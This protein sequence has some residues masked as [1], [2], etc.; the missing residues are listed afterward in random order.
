MEAMM[1][2]SSSP[3]HLSRPPKPLF[4]SPLSFPSLLK[5]KGNSRHGVVL[6]PAMCIPGPIRDT[7]KSEDEEGMQVSSSSSSPPSLSISTYN[8]CAGLGGLGFL[9]TAYLT[10]LKVSNTEPF[11]PVG[12]GSCSDVLNSDYAVILGVPLPLIGMTAY[13][14][15]FLLGLKLGGWNVPLK[16]SQSDGRV[17]LLPVSASMAAASAYFLYTLA[18]RLEG[19]SCSYCL[20]SATLSFSLFF[21]VLKDF[22]LKELQKVVALPLCTAAIVLG[23]LNT[24]YSSLPPISPRSEVMEF[25]YYTTE[26]TSASSPYAI[27]LAKHL[28]ST[29]AK[30]YGA[31]WCSH[32]QEQ[33][34]MF[35]RE[36]MKLL[37]YVEC[38]P[39]GVKKG[40][41]IA[42]ACSDV[43]IE[44]FPTWLI[45]GEVISGEKTLE[46]LAEISDFHYDAVNQPN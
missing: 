4:S 5:F 8:W 2:S 38:F 29:G 36:A 39:D 35:G 31:F 19:A 32:C 17:L 34:E 22:G 25:P 20:A 15:I 27:S 14:L 41:K 42:S 33:K 24:T 40:I 18:T 1:L 30:M 28:K 44:G 37:D 21:I 23:I 16:I 9:E 43:G 7:E 26:I 45:N 11:C 46:E 13:G 12:G 6:L 3:L 10:Y